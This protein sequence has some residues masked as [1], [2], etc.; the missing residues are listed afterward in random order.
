[1]KHFN[2]NKL[3]IVAAAFVLFLG[4]VGC[5]SFLDSY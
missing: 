1:M 3:V 2:W 5:S 4:L